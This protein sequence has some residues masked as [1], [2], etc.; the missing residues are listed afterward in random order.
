[1][2]AGR[3]GKKKKK[4]LHSIEKKLPLIAD[5]ER[6]NRRERRAYQKIFE[7]SFN[8]SC[9]RIRGVVTRFHPQ[10]V[11]AA[12]NISDLWLPNI[13]SQVKHQL[14]FSL[15]ASIPIENFTRVRM[16]TYEDFAEFC[17]SLIEIFPDFPSLEDYLPESD[18]GE[19]KF[20]LKDE[21]ASILYGGPVQRITDYMEAF[22][23]AHGPGSQAMLDL[24]NAIALQHEFLK[25]VPSN[26]TDQ[27]DKAHPGHIEVPPQSFW[28]IAMSALMRPLSDTKL[29]SNLITNLG[30]V[31]TWKNWNEFGDAIMTGAVLPWLAISIDGQPWAMSLRN[32]LSVVIDKW[33]KSTPDSHINVAARLGKFLRNRIQSRSCL[34]GPLILRTRSERIPLTIS[35]VLFQEQS[36]YLVVPVPAAQLPHIGKAVTSMRRILKDAPD[37]GLQAVGSSDGFQLRDE[38]GKVPGLADVEVILVVTQVTTAPYMLKNPDATTHLMTLI[39]ACTIFDSVESVSELSRFW[40]YVDGLDVMG[41]SSFSDLG[42]LFG[43]FRDVHAQIVEGAVVPNFLMLDPHWGASWRFRELKEYWK[44]APRTLPDGDSSWTVGER[45]AKSSLTRVIAKNLPKLAW[46]AAIGECTVHFIL[47]ADAVGLDPQ[48]GTL[49]E[50]F[51]HCAADSIAERELEIKSF[52]EIPFQQVNLHCFSAPDLLPSAS[53]EQAEIA[54]SKSLVTDWKEM[55]R[56]NTAV[57]QAKLTVNLTKLTNELENAKDAQ[58]E[59]DCVRA[60]LEG[61]SVVLEKEIPERLYQVLSQTISRPPRF[62]LQ[63]K[64]R[65]VDVPDFTQAMVPRPEDYKVARRDLAIL[66]KDQGAAPGTY[67]LE[68]AKAL[69]DPA[70]TGY[71]DMV[72]RRIKELDRETLLLFCVKQY[73]ALISAHDREEIRIQQSLSHQVDYDRKKTLSA[74]R[75]AFVRESRNYRYLIESALF[76]TSTQL[77]PVRAETV[78]SVLSMIDWLSV[79]YGASDVLHNGIDVGG[80]R[81]DEQYVPDIFYSEAREAQETEFGLEIAAL[82]LGVNVTEDDKLGTEL[83]VEEY[84]DVLDQAFGSDLQFTFT[85]L[86]QVLATLT[87]WVAVGGGDA[88]A[89]GYISDRQT[90]AEHAVSAHNDMTILSALAVIEFLVLKPDQVRRLIG[91]S[92]DEG[93]VPVWEHSKRGSRHTIRPLIELPDGR[94]LW[95]AAA[96]A[97]A[98]RIWSGSVSAGYLPADFAWPSVRKAVGELK[99]ELEDGLEDRA[100][101][102]FARAMPYVIKG[103]DFKYRFPKQQFP[104]VG[105]FDVLAYLPD[106]NQWFAV[107]CKYN[108]PAHCLKDTRRLRDRIFGGGSELGQFKKIEGRRDFFKKN[109]D[110]LRDLL[111]WPKPGN[112]DFLFT[113]LYVSKDMHFWLRF[114][115]YE[116]PTHF[117]QVDTLDAWLKT[118]GMYKRG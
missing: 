89:C 90:M 41:G 52:I 54:A 32:A 30:Q 67:E 62:N 26:G 48:D 103:I 109:V 64:Q 115:P 84:M 75:E 4:R 56:T 118:A 91:K 94:L 20:V 76:L 19:I 110:L 36:Y 15:L 43:S 50:L 49:L 7:D 99:K 5:W 21:P 42:D 55:P 68:V 86:L 53:E 113:E 51:V 100:Y 92:I 111:G 25:R 24:E 78:L 72:H 27:I 65:S 63:H 28:A 17:T 105:D 88:L 45:E 79:L 3:N 74:S 12:L 39:D 13:G 87:S 37:W 22:R 71:R 33:T 23:I 82:R 58:F 38:Q 66:L 107:E 104:D 106:Q 108:Q 35:A 83:S 117:V 14:A 34:P 2:K 112:T 29:Q 80:L 10:D 16:S 69:I 31:V 93:D 9:S 98:A 57:Y 77:T 81:V 101:E 44:L 46:S 70:R 1:M 85:Q 114:P 8:E 6:E 47:D 40:K 96:V 11:L 97:R 73:D 60:V 116:V 18:W 102:I 61:L 95:G 59:V